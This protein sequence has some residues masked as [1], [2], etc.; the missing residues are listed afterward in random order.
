MN[1]SN[2]DVLFSHNVEM[3]LDKQYNHHYFN[4][5][6][7]WRADV[8]C[9]SSISGDL[10]QVQQIDVFVLP[11]NPRRGEAKSRIRILASQELTDDDRQRGSVELGVKVIPIFLSL[12]HQI[13]IGVVSPNPVK[14]SYWGH[15]LKKEPRDSARESD[16]QIEGINAWFRKGILV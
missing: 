7:T 13:K 10:S 16:F 8:I 1:V 3:N 4:S 12:N 2:Q 9:H 6:P 11:L 15:Y 14:L 5:T